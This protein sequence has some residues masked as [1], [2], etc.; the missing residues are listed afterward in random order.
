MPPLSSPEEGC[1]PRHSGAERRRHRRVAVDI[2][3]TIAL[4]DGSVEGRIRDLSRAGVCFFLDR[5]IPEMTMLGMQLTLP[6]EDGAPPASLRGSGVVVRCM[7]LSPRLAHYEIAVFLSA[8]GAE[9][10]AHLERF[11]GSRAN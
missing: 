9:D 7:R 8:I 1:A 6:R 3:I 4:T 11:I 10:L 5:P 2:P